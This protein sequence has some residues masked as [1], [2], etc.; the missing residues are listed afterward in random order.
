MIKPNWDVFKAK[1]SKN[2]QDNFE[3]LCYLLFCREFDKR[4]GIFRYK[5]QAGIETNL[6]HTDNEVIGWQAKFYDSKLSEK[7]SEIIEAIKKAKEHYPTTITTL[8]FYSH[9]DWTENTKETDD[10][11]KT[12]AQKDIEK[13]TS[14]LG[15]KLVWKTA[16]FF[17]S[18]SVSIENDIIARHF[19]SLDE[20]VF[21]KVEEFKEHTQTILENIQ[22]QIIFQGQAIQIDR[23]AEI[24]QIKNTSHQVIVLNGE[25]GVGKTA[26][27]KALLEQE[28][29][30]FFYVFKATE[31]SVRRV[32]DFFSGLKVEDFIR[33]HE[34][35]VNKFVAIDSAEKLLDLDDDS[36]FREFLSAFINSGWKLIVTSR[37]SYLDDLNNLLIDTYKITPSYIRISN[38]ALEN[39][40][41]LST[42]NNFSLPL[43]EKL[44]NFIRNPFYLN[45]Y[46]ENYTGEN[47][48]YIEFKAKLWKQKIIKSKPA[49]EQC[50]LKIVEEKV[51]TGQFYIKD[52]NCENVVLKSLKKSE[53]LNYQSP[54]GYFIVHDIYEEWALEQVIKR[55][56]SRKININSFFEK[57]GASLPVLRSFRNWL[58]E[59]F[60][61]KNNSINSFI[62][63][64]IDE[65]EIE[66]FW[67]D[68]VW[69]SILLSNNAGYFFDIFKNELLEDEQ[70]LLV[71]L[72]F[73]LQV[74]CHTVN[75]DILKTL[76]IPSELKYVFTKPKGQGWD[77]V[78]KF[79]CEH[80]DEL[81]LKHLASILPVLHDW[82][83]SFK[84]G[85]TTRYASLI[86]LKYYELSF[87]KQNERNSRFWLSSNEKRLIQVIVYGA[88]EIKIELEAIFTKILENKWRKNNDPYNELSNF[89]L[90]NYF[91]TMDIAPYYS[92]YI[93]RLADL[94][95]FRHFDD[96]KKKLE[97]HFYTYTDRSI[98]KDFNIIA[99][100][101]FKYNQASALQTPIYLLLRY[102]PKETIDFILEFTNK[103]VEYYVQ[104]SKLDKNVE[105]ITIYL[106]DRTI[107]Q[108]ASDRL[109]GMYRGS[110]VSPSVLESTHMA[111]E[112]TLL[113]IAEDKQFDKLEYYLLYLLENSKSASISSIVASIVLAYPEETFNIATILFR[114]KEFFFYDIN[115]CTS[116]RNILFPYVLN[117]YDKQFREERIESANLYHRKRTLGHIFLQYQLAE[118][119]P[120]SDKKQKIIWGILDNYYKELP[121]IANQSDSE[122]EWN[123]YLEKIDIRRN[124][125]GDIEQISEN[126]FLLPLTPDL[127]PELKSYGESKLE[128]AYEPVKYIELNFWALA[129]LAK[130]EKANKHA[131]Y[132]HNPKLALQEAK[133]I[134]NSKDNE[135][136]K[137]RDSTVS[138]V[139][140]VLVKKY[141]GLLASEELDFCI[142]IIF[143]FLWFPSHINKNNL[144]F[145]EEDINSALMIL[146]FLSN[147]YPDISQDLKY[148]LFLTIISD[149]FYDERMLNILESVVTELLITH[150][151]DIYSII[152]SYLFLKPK[153][154]TLKYSN[155]GEPSKWTEKFIQGN[156]ASLQKM[157]DNEI[158]LDDIGDITSLDAR[159]LNMAFQI[160]P[161]KT[162]HLEQENLAKK[163]ITAFTKKLFPDEQ[164]DFEVVEDE[165]I[166]EI[167]Q[168]INHIQFNWQLQNPFLSKDSVH[169][170]GND[171]KEQLNE[172]EN[173]FYREIAEKVLIS[174]MNNFEIMGSESVENDC[175][176]S[177]Q[178]QEQKEKAKQLLDIV[179]KNL[180]FFHNQEE[181]VDIQISH[182]FLKKL[183]HFILSLPQDNIQ[184]YLQPFLQ[185]CDDSETTKEF[186]NQL[187]LAADNL[188]NYQNFWAIWK[189]CKNKVIELNK[190]YSC[191]SRTIETY[192]FAETALIQE[193]RFKYIDSR[194]FKNISKE[195]GHCPATLYAVSKLL[196]DV[197]S[198]YLNENDGITWVSNIIEKHGNKLK[199]Y[200]EENTIT[201]LEQL[202]R[203]FIYGNL[204]NIRE[205]PELKRKMLI[206]LDF[207]VE[208]GS[209][210]GYMQRERIL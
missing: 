42:Q 188:D 85:K 4:F 60:F 191:S 44:L 186:F 113:E 190:N 124:H 184:K 159:I 36:P 92:S 38:L 71:K 138:N 161:I 103:T 6:I 19:F 119:N 97:P 16:S 118:G 173:E 84:K 137:W 58:S 116:E 77:A 146:P 126:C 202:S 196:N 133:E 65:E 46:L 162:E 100:T 54:D 86:A 175:L 30:P 32:N 12:Q 68:E 93:L 23:T 94:F 181:E 49:R 64:V 140:C 43:D 206:I 2:P 203:K 195:L 10:K 147:Q 35:E 160:M 62:E 53:I 69:V 144:A 96:K 99:N 210:V 204:K 61:L 59:Q 165:E 24:E 41:T 197:G 180:T 1:F 104:Y 111:L 95:W 40:E 67:K 15:I 110:V 193:D 50:F 79:I 108:Y 136:R 141:A 26:V 81:P 82:N 34:K 132:E 192:L 168:I 205:K 98:E 131:K 18:P 145:Y 21:D 17:E 31:F 78:I 27:V 117:M 148:L 182:A 157:I 150:P 45:A 83:N 201:Y 25:A 51:N 123:L 72:C 149:Y 112:K 121:E 89:I 52:T 75:E 135:L 130:E 134:I 87:E 107:I 22:T 48:D 142:G 91:D 178:N 90:S 66:N 172:I 29:Y 163:I 114:T 127:S 179:L 74:A 174:L 171:E 176:K 28:Q 143:E 55:E 7:K 14:E 102:S 199:N 170:L 109:W 9:Q 105:E 187:I 3:W 153:Y 158:S 39:L 120:E 151:N 63:N 194:F 156:E 169:V 167:A 198:C 106:R 80:F 73:L 185:S 177:L 37:D 129:K 70:S 13:S 33:F 47:V 128:K 208:N 200:L 125:I 56:F 101:D 209:K 164:L 76:G 139:C 207:L 155:Y 115:R 57:I 122:K 88:Y 152:C 183:A 189:L 20:S 8:Y 5:N 11:K 154:E 166:N